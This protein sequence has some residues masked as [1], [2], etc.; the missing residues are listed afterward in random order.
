[1]GPAAAPGHEDWDLTNAGKQAVTE[2]GVTP[3][4]SSM[5]SR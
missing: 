2:R 5:V 1:M 4:L 3:V